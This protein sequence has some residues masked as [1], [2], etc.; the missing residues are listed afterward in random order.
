MRVLLVSPLPPPYGGIAHWTQLMLT[1]AI[2]S[3]DSEVELKVLDTA[4]RQ[5]RELEVRRLARLREGVGRMLV[6]NVRLV[7]SLVDYR[8]DIIHLNTSGQLAFVR[9]AVMSVLMGIFRV[10]FV[11]HLRFGRMPEI[12]AAETLEWRIAR[13]TVRRAACIIAL[14]PATEQA[15]RDVGVARSVVRIP[16]PIPDDR[17]LSAH[18]QRER[19]NVV[20]F[21]G[22]VIP[23]KGIGELLTAWESI[24]HRNWRLEIAGP[25][26]SDYLE[27]LEKS[28]IPEG[29]DLLGGLD[30]NEIMERLRRSKVFALPSYTE[31]FPNAVLE[32]MASGVAVVS[33]SVGAIPD[34]LS[35]GSGIVVPPRDPVALAGALDRL[36]IDS[37]LARRM[38]VSAWETARDR[39]SMSTVF[40]CYKH[41]WLES[42]QRQAA[43]SSD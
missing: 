12:I 18:D 28:G 43:A 7:R 16:N 19:R 10:P 13:F 38:G 26:D 41:L 31:G 35:G 21:V 24:D 11:Y 5:R 25:A 30:N 33:T 27:L 39:F 17:I 9:D 20:L 6:D 4:P 23:A 37:D 34:M 2:T 36:M 15:L 8:P 14:D 22:W 42:S 1:H 40:E 3:R 29:V 32:A